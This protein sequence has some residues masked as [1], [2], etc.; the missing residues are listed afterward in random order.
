MMEKVQIDPDVMI[1]EIP[2]VYGGNAQGE[3]LVKQG[4]GHSHH[5][6]LGPKTEFI[7]SLI[8]GLLLLTG[9]FLSLHKGAAPAIPIYFYIGAYLFGGFYTTRE[10]VESIKK[11]EFEIDFLMLV[12]AIGAGILGQ[13]SDGAL[14]LFLFSMGHSLEHFA[15]EK[16]RKSIAALADL[17]PK[18]ALLKIDGD[19]KEVGIE[20]LSPGD[21]IVVRPHTKISADGIVVGGNSCVNQAPITGESIPVDKR[22]VIDPN[23]DISKAKEIDAEHQVFAGSINGNES[24]EVKV[25]KPASDS[26][27]SRL[28]RMVHEAQSQKSPTQHFSDQ[29]EKY[30]VPFVLILVVLLCFAFLVI[31]EPFSKSFYRAMTVL[32][33]ASPCALAISTPS[34]VLSGV[35]RAAR[36]GVLIKGGKPLEDVGTLKAIAFDKTGTLTEGKPKLTHIIPSQHTTEKELLI[37]TVAVEALSDHPLAKAIVRD[38][39]GKLGAQNIPQAQNLEAIIGKGIKA[40]L[41]NDVVY[42]GNLRLFDSLDAFKPSD[43]LIKEVKKLED[44]GNTTMIV[45]KNE[46]YA[47]IIAVM[48]IPRKEAKETLRQLKEVGI[49]RMVMLTGDNQKVAD[50]VAKQIGITDVW[51]SLLPEQ[52]VEAIKKL[53]QKEKKVAMVGDGVNDAPAMALSTAGITMGAAGSDVALETADIALMGDQL[54]LLPFAIGLSRQAKRIIKQNVFISL[55]MIAILIPLTITGMASIGPAVIAHEGSTIVVVLN[56]LRLLAYKK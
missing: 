23:F 54:N 26:T 50:A 24:L 25:S 2:N 52:K 34:A 29:F 6:I 55:G 12:A 11:G 17:A 18:T 8:C 33:A 3:D 35:A 47:G 31:D 14:L 44:A 39:L 43:E 4:D 10:A 15:M 7:F 37:I 20:E 56:A 53:K 13:W 19:V 9:F 42:I 28:V 46:E 36:A 5:R 48:D 1:P 16:A 22:A 21:I 40:S 49:H 32:I 38:G 30:F 41:D 45:R 51:G 27:I